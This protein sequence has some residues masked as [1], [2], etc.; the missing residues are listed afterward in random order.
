MLMDGY[1]IMAMWLIVLY[2]ELSHVPEEDKFV[3]LIGFAFY[4]RHIG[5]YA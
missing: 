4:F 5:A 3:Y 1:I 2:D